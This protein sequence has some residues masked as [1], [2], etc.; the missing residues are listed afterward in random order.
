MGKRIA[1]AAFV[2][3]SL[4]GALTFHP[5]TA[6]EWIGIAVRGLF[7]SGLALGVSWIALAAV[8]FLYGYSIAAPITKVRNAVAASKWRRHAELE[9]QRRE[10]QDRR[11]QWEE[12]DR[13]ARE[14]E[15]ERMKAQG[16]QRRADARAKAYRTFTLYAP[17]LHDRFTQEMRDEYVA[18]FMGDEHPPEGVER[19]GE[20]LVEILQKHLDEVEPPTKARTLEDLTKWYQEQKERIESLPVEERVKRR[21]IAGLNTRYAELSEQ[22]MENL[23]P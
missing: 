13:A 11:R 5:A 7:A 3:Y 12:A 14:R 15:R 22:L 1:A 16:Q 17:K 21:H 18:Q 8:A 2:A 4:Y 9:R 19:R 10:E 6:K 23:Q 20:E